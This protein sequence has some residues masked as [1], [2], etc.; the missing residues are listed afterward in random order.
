MVAGVFAG[1]LVSSYP[2]L[3][4]LWFVFGM[5]FSL[6]LMPSGRLIRRSAGPVDRPALFAAQFALSH[7]C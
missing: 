7:A 3:L 1:P 4:A 6:A 2:Q 5:G